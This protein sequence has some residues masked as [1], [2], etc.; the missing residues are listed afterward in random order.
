MDWKRVKSLV[1]F[2]DPRGA[3]PETGLIAI[4]GDLLPER[5]VSAYAH[6]IFPWY[7]EDPILWFSPDPRMVLCL[8]DLVINRTL[9]KN[10]V[11][12]KFEVR[13]DTVFAE[14]IQAC[15]TVE[16]PDQDGTWIT[17]EMMDGYIALHELGYAHSVEAFFDGRLVGG[18]YGV[19]LGS[20]FFGESMF[21]N[22]NDASKVAFV[23]LVRQ[24][25]AW[26]FEFI[27]CQVHTEHL[28]RLGATEWRRHDFLDALDVALSRETRQ[29]KWTFDPDFSWMGNR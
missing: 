19:S 17:R 23:H 6:G 15:A 7:N 9:Q 1:P 12:E 20:A 25:E 2:P 13:L 22:E 5:L 18:M 4:G 3:D 24:L 26:D 14:V 16:R 10:L 21:A 28:S 29:G 8:P 27:D 11:R